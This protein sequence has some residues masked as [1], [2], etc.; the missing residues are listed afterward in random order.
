MKDNVIEELKKKISERL[1]PAWNYSTMHPVI[2]L[3]AIVDILEK[4]LPTSE[5]VECENCKKLQA[6]LDDV[7]F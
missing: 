2:S 3:N 4:Y 7:P 1:V 5:K 6:Q